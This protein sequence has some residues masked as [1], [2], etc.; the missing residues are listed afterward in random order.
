MSSNHLAV[1]RSV[2]KSLHLGHRSCWWLR[3]KHGW[4]IIDRA[5]SPL[6]NL[7]NL[8]TTYGDWRILH[9]ALYRSWHICVRP[10]ELVASEFSLGI[11]KI[12]AWCSPIVFLV[13]RHVI[14]FVREIKFVLVIGYDFSKPVSEFSLLQSQDTLIDLLLQNFSGVLILHQLFHSWC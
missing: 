6:L 14:L 4:F 10:V 12:R 2:A 5:V 1:R 9:F 11:R 8:F 13:F 3:H 7:R